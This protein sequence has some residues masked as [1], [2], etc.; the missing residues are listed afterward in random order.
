M[1]CAEV[2]MLGFWVKRRSEHSELHVPGEYATRTERGCTL[3]WS[4]FFARVRS[5]SK[6]VQYVGTT[7]FEA[8]RSFPLQYSRSVGRYVSY[9]HEIPLNLTIDPR[10]NTST[11]WVTIEIPK[12]TNAKIETQVRREGSP[13]L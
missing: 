2:Q 9:W 7:R 5:Y 10:D 6:F 3:E 11:M 13:D 1:H 12:G 4:L 8:L